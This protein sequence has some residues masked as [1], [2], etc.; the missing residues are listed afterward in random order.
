MLHFQSAQHMLEAL[1][2]I[3]VTLRIT[4]LPQDKVY[5]LAKGMIGDAERYSFL[6]SLTFYSIVLQVIAGKR[7]YLIK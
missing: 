5:Y 6:N 4:I 7:R 3:F 2:R 1:L